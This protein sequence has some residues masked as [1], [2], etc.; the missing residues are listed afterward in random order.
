VGQTVTATFYSGQPRSMP[1]ESQLE[2]SFMTVERMILEKD[3][4]PNE[5]RGLDAVDRDFSSLQETW[6]FSRSTEPYSRSALYL[7]QHFPSAYV[8]RRAKS[9]ND[10]PK[11]T[12]KWVAIRDDNDWDT[13]FLW[14]KPLNSLN[15]ISYAQLSWEIGSEG[16][17]EQGHSIL[18]GANVVYR[19]RY[20]GVHKS[21]LGRIF[22]HEGFSEVFQILDGSNY[23]AWVELNGGRRILEQSKLLDEVAESLIAVESQG[24]VDEEQMSRT[25]R[26][27]SMP[28]QPQLQIQ[29]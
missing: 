17:P 1:V 13:R 14:R 21:V 4:F 2:S 29:A 15:P 16:G 26:L 9:S 8:G 23:D 18:H 24:E 27:M 7:A 5:L 20:Y 28:F 6:K 12:G 10:R 11:L 19:L 22:R 25:D 3:V